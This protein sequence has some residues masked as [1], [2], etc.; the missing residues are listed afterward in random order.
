M[1]EPLSNEKFWGRVRQSPNGCW[2]WQGAKSGRGYGRLSINGEY[3]LSH[4][5]AYVLSR[6]EIPNGMLVCHTCDNP[7]CCNPDHLF[8]GTVKDNADDMVSKGR[9]YRTPGEKCSTA[10]LTWDVVQQIRDEFAT[11][12]HT[13]KGLARK[14]GV[15][16]HTIRRAI[17]GQTW[18]AEDH[19]Q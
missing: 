2:E 3:W 7:S 8:L 6:G 10:K 11:G 4:R 15:D 13:K 17:L 16:Q 18:R 1:S 19:G 5:L 14:Y 12:E 9:N